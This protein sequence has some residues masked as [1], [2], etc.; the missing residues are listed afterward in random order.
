MENYKWIMIIGG[1][2]GAMFLFAMAYLTLKLVESI[3][4]DFPIPIREPKKQKTKNVIK[5]ITGYEKA[6]R[7]YLN[8]TYAQPK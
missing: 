6:R 5:P 3:F 8:S 7:D 1:V 2:S 4:V